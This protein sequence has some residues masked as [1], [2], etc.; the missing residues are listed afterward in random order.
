MKKIKINTCQLIVALCLFVLSSCDENNDP[1]LLFEDTPTVRIEKS[2]AELKTALQGS[3]N[4]WKTTYF[5]DDSEL[6][7]F[8]F[9][10]DFI[11]DS[12]VIM[13]SDFGTPDVSA[14]SL[15]DIT[16]GS[17]VKLTFTTKNVIHQ[18]SDSNNFPDDDLRGQG[19]KGSFEFLYFKTEGDDILF[20][21][22]RDRDIIIR[23][24]KASKEDWTS[25]TSL[26]KTMLETNIPKNP[27]KSVFRNITLESGGKTTLY[28]FSFNEARRFATVTAIS[29][30]A[31]KT[32]LSFGIA[33]KPTGF[34]VSPAIEIENVVLEE[35]IYNLDDDEFVAEVDGVK[36][37][38]SYADELSFLLPFYDFGNESR[39]NN[40]MRLYR[41][42]L[43]NSDLSSENFI[44]FYKEWEAHFT[45]TQS[46]RTVTRVY[47][48]NLETVDNSFVQV[49]YLSSGRS[50][51]LNFKFTY[52]VTENAT[53][54]KI[55]KLTETV[56]VNTTRRAGI[57]PLLDFLFRDSG[58]YVQKMVDFNA[59]QNTLGIIPVDD[60]TML[61]Q[62]YD[63]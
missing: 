22:N 18:L 1:E 43:P 50:F 53:G 45:A 36:I 44:N 62:W 38:L 57:L 15:Y 13:D 37:T 24:S 9:L 26:N 32:D 42:N 14:T 49:R 27:L 2:I 51:S 8:T 58:F 21:S 33:P 60:T 40:N 25:L 7:G 11:S 3:E 12:E 30:D 41:T 54:N 23:F 16:L 35:F 55:Y 28:G 52:T 31:V 29:K 19:Y 34:V 10:F 4:G 59:N 20:K 39:G 6:G 5:T 46:G 47:L 63:F 17:T 56:P 61:A 48:Y